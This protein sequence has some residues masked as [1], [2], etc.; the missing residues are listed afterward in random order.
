MY[1]RLFDERLGVSKTARDLAARVSIH[2]VFG[3]DLHYV[4]RSR[5]DG[6]PMPRVSFMESPAIWAMH[7][8][9]GWD[10]IAKIEY[11]RLC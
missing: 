10:G 7:A 8:R 1:T 5:S 3:V 2:S 4:F 11:G 9:N 6:S